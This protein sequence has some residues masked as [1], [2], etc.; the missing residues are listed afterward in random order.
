MDSVVTTGEAEGR[1]KTAPLSTKNSQEFGERF[2]AA[3]GC[4]CNSAPFLFILQR[5]TSPQTR[6]LLFCLPYALTWCGLLQ[7]QLRCLPPQLPLSL[8]TRQ[9]AHSDLTQA[10]RGGTGTEGSLEPD[11]IKG[12]I[13][14]SGTTP[15]Q[16]LSPPHPLSSYRAN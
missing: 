3:E 10:H 11:D 13:C 7:Q 12:I 8:T 15:S 9:T 4:S 14:C 2:M 6:R 16:F 1:K 5:S